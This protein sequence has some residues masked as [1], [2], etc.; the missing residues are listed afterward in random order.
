MIAKMGW[1]RLTTK[2][3]REGEWVLM[4][5]SR[6]G[7]VDRYRAG[8]HMGVDDW[9]SAANTYEPNALLRD[10]DVEYWMPLPPAPVA[11]PRKPKRQPLKV[12]FGGA[13]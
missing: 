7:G 2:R 12:T 8:M 5:L 11:T 1:V 9:M 3:P 10:V 6:Y 4:Y 13:G